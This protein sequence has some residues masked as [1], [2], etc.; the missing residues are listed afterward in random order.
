M[1]GNIRRS[2]TTAT[3][4]VDLANKGNQSVSQSINKMKLIHHKTEEANA[5]TRSLNQHAKEIDQVMIFIGQIST[6][7]NLL[8]LNASIE[9]ARAQEHGRGFLV[10]AEEV[11]ELSVQ[12]KQAAEQV[13]ALIQKLQQES[14]QSVQ[15][16]AD[17]QSIVE[18]G[19]EQ[20]NVSP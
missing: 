1:T 5:I 14:T 9:A 17:V 8:A 3:K 12:T 6:Q 13:S 16:G 2:A 11:R 15:T 20:I 18:E 7:T 10:V 4:T 19:I